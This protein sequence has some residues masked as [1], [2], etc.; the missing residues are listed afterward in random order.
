MAESFLLSRTPRSRVVNLNI[1][2]LVFLALQH[3][4]PRAVNL[5]IYLALFSAVEQAPLHL[6]GSMPYVPCQNDKKSLTL[7]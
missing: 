3:L 2:K 6:Y 7:K 1:E 4:S 5:A